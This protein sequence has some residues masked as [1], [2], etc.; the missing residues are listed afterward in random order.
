MAK[1]RAKSP[2]FRLT[3]AEKVAAIRQILFPGGDLNHEWD[4]E[5]LEDIARVVRDYE[6]HTGWTSWPPRRKRARR[7]CA[8]RACRS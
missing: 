8:N 6:F 3:A 7:D 5:Y 1:A 2:H 4:V